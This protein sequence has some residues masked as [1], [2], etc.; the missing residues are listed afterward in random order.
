MQK[1]GVN[2]K[3]GVIPKMSSKTDN[4]F[5]QIGYEI[6]ILQSMPKLL[7]E[8]GNEMNI[9]YRI[10]DEKLQI[11]VNRSCKKC[12]EFFPIGDGSL[13]CKKCSYH[14]FWLERGMR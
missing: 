10:K 7:D 2:L 14:K 8:C 9:H 3:N 5:G 12:T 1:F 11:L 13:I 6:E 4:L